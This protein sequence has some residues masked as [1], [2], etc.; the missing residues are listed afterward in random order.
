MKLL[1]TSLNEELETLNKN[2]IRFKTIGNLEKL[3]K[4]LASYLIKVTEKTQNNMSII[5]LTFLT[6][7]RISGVGFRFYDLT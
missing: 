6:R 2:N 3:P 7:M 1:L 4:K 5:T